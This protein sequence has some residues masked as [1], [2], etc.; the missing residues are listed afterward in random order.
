MVKKN[1]SFYTVIIRKHTLLLHGS[2][3]IKQEA[4][5]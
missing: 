3:V 5:V 2:L 4:I 1:Y